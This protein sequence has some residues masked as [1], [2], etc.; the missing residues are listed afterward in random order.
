MSSYEYMT[1]N[2]RYPS[3][4]ERLRRFEVSTAFHPGF[5]NEVIA[6]NVILQQHARKLAMEIAETMTVDRAAGPITVVTTEVFVCSPIDF[7]AA[8]DSVAEHFINTRKI[9]FNL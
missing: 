2:S 3:I 6:R 1:L 8:V 7:W 9:D 5:D 4:M